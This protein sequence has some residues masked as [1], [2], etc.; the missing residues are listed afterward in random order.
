MMALVPNAIECMRIIGEIAE[1]QLGYVT[2]AQAAAQG[3][4]RTQIHRLAAGGALERA[5]TGIYRVV[6]AREHRLEYIWASWL[7][8]DP[9][10]SYEQRLKEPWKGPVVMTEAATA[11]HEVGTFLVHDIDISTPYRIQS[12]NELLTF[13]RRALAPEDVVIVEGVPVTTIPK[14]VADLVVGDRDRSIIGDLIAR[15]RNDGGR[16]S[17]GEIGEALDKIPAHKRE[18]LSGPDFLERITI[19]WLPVA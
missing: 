14:T 19:D 18:H 11:L 13:H 3:V 16:I 8:L 6:G 1:W 17:Y 12:R 5:R 10:R 7:A 2:S 4:P 9:T 15:H